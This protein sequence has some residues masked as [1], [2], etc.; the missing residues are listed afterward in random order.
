MRWM[1]W[2]F[3]G[4]CFFIFYVI[5]I[6]MVVYIFGILFILVVKLRVYY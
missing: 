1:K 3:K 4:D 5:G 6:R 2:G